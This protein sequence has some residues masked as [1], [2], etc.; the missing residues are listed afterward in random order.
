MIG[1]PEDASSGASDPFLRLVDEA[2]AAI[3]EPFASHLGSVAVLVDDEATTEQLEQL[4]VHGLYGLYEG[5]PRT[6]W[7][8]SHASVPSRITIYR[9]PLEERYREADALRQAVHDVVFHE[10]AHHFGIGDERLDELER[11]RRRRRRAE[12]TGP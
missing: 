6:V 3:P 4:G 12:R 1:D 9:R 10:V 5:V 11:E 8:A 2:I 7:G